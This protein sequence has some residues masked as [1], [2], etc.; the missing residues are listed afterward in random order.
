VIM[1]E[2]GLVVH[3]EYILLTRGVFNDR[4]NTNVLLGKELVLDCVPTLDN[5]PESA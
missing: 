3:E 5:E 2:S 1:W 4:N